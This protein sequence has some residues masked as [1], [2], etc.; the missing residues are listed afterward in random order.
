MAIAVLGLISGTILYAIW[1]D[2][3]PDLYFDS[4]NRRLAQNFIWDCDNC[5]PRGSSRGLSLIPE[6]FE[7]GMALSEVEDSLFSS[8]YEIEN[9]GTK[10]EYQ[11]EHDPQHGKEYLV[12]RYKL[13]IGQLMCTRDFMIYVASNQDRKVEKIIG[14]K[15]WACL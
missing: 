9:A 6:H 2:Y 8:G 12:S 3:R 5:A 7:K 14:Y 4:L 13:D 15:T 10:S 11:L 1:T